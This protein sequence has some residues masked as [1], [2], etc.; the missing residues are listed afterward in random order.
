VPVAVVRP[1]ALALVLRA[2]R[3]RGQAAG[4][5]LPAG[6]AID[7]VGDAIYFR[8]SRAAEADALEQRLSLHDD[9]PPAGSEQYVYLRL[10]VPDGDGLVRRSGKFGL[11]QGLAEL[12]QR[13]VQL[14]ALKR[15]D[16]K[17][18]AA[19]LQDFTMS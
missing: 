17:A 1:A 5:E 4:Q 11:E 6:A 14:A 9:L 13:P 12:G 18:S 15:I 2:S 3:L 19:E 7:L 10:S 16:L 8:C